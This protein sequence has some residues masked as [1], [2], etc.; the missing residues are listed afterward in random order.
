M[1]E[2]R[3]GDAELALES[4]KKTAQLKGCTVEKLVQFYEGKDPVYGSTL[5]RLIS[6]AE[7]AVNGSFPEGT[8]RVIENGA[9]VCR[10]VKTARGRTEY[11]RK[12]R[13]PSEIP[14]RAEA[15]GTRRDEWKRL[16]F[17]ELRKEAARRENHRP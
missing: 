10:R 6:E 2:I 3:R 9:I 16:S 17:P 7:E 8:I 15:A 4:I 13:V 5:R 12:N 14:D 11:R 1:A